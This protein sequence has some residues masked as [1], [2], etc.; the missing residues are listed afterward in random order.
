MRNHYRRVVKICYSEADED[1]REYSKTAENFAKNLNLNIKPL[2]GS[3][4][5]MLEALQS[6]WSMIQKSKS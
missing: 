6:G 2:K 5:I 4:K 1:D 3:A